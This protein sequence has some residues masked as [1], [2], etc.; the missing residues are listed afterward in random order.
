[1]TRSARSSHLPGPGLTEARRIAMLALRQ[2]TR[3]EGRHRAVARALQHPTVAP[4]AQRRT[5][6]R[7]KDV[8][9]RLED[10]RCEGA[11]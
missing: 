1:V 9:I 5:G 11:P 2:R 7:R 4:R 3:C 6:P 10:D 8:A